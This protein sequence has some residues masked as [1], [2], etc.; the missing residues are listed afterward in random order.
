MP[1]TA[2]EPVALATF[3]TTCQ[4]RKVTERNTCLTLQHLQIWGRPQSAEVASRCNAC[5]VG[6]SWT[7]GSGHDVHSTCLHFTTK[8]LKK[9]QKLALATSKL[10]LECMF[11]GMAAERDQPQEMPACT[12]MLFTC[13][14][15]T[16][17][18]IHPVL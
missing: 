6:V 14:D 4:M 13:S 12:S 15:K 17:R 1:G 2:A 11:S 16:Q 3:C 7:P 5:L 18:A 8:T 9:T 10:L